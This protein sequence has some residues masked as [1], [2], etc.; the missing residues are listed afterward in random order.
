MYIYILYTYIHTHIYM[1]IYIYIYIYIYRRRSYLPM[2]EERGEEVVVVV[3]V[4]LVKNWIIAIHFV[5]DLQALL[6]YV[7]K[8]LEFPV[9]E[10]VKEVKLQIQIVMTSSNETKID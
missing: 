9:E 5:V 10:L 8:I 2:E 4:V 1:Y 3:V 7:V 6:L